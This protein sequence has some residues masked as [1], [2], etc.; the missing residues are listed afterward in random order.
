MDTATNLVD[1]AKGVTNVTG[2]ELF[3]LTASNMMPMTDRERIPFTADWNA[4]KVRE[5]GYGSL[6]DNPYPE[7]QK[8]RL[9]YAGGQ[10]VLPTLGLGGRQSI[11]SAVRNAT[12]GFASNVAGQGAAEQGLDSSGQLLAALAV[13]AFGSTVGS[14]G[15]GKV[16][17]IKQANIERAGTNQTAKDFMN[18]GGSLPPSQINPTLANKFLQGA[19]AGNPETERAI[20]IKNAPVINKIARNELGLPKN[21]DLTIENIN[22]SPKVEE[23]KAIYATA[24]KLPPITIDK[25]SFE[26]D[27][28]DAFK[29]YES[30]VSVDKKLG[31]T[32][33]DKLISIFKPTPTTPQ[34]GGR[35]FNLG[36]SA[37]ALNPGLGN[38]MQQHG[39][40][41]MSSGALMDISASLREEGFTNRA[42][43]SGK[44]KRLGSIQLDIA[45][46]L[47]SQMA[48]HAKDNGFPALGEDLTTAR[49]SFAK[50]FEIKDALEKSTRKIIAKSIGKA[51]GESDRLS[52][53]LKTIGAAQEAFPSS[54]QDVSG[55]PPG[56]RTT[57]PR[58]WAYAASL[59]AGPA[60]TAYTG[61]PYGMLLGALPPLAVGTRAFL[62][63]KLGQKMLAR[64]MVEKPRASWLAQS[65]LEPDMGGLLGAYAVPPRD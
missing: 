49:T 40:Q 41:T 45:N 31:D 63:S 4:N 20:A 1:L 30:V 59:M 5:L 37:L 15:S 26:A 65:L 44:L 12:M 2:G 25:P 35:Q 60:A 24:K 16:A 21:A 14:W 38:V 46:A 13:P 52:G 43:D 33:I 56:F 50:A 48:R 7:D 57:D 19:L 47:D 54:L 18:Q 62:T 61:S 11:P 3:G 58:M 28:G 6:I 64:P 36:A 53:G 51:F 10:A 17:K 27:L 23:A 55:P 9:A 22:A 32:K 29:R 34:I 39:G 8:S 42:A